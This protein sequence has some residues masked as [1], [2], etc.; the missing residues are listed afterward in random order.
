MQIGIY[1]TLTILRFTSVG[2]YLGDE[3]DNDVLLPNKYLT[4]DLEIDQEIEVFLYK[5]SEDRPV[6]TTETPKIT[7]HSF[8][9][10]QVKSVDSIG[11]FLDWGLEKDL[12]VP[13]K[14]QKSKMKEGGNYL[15]YLYL[16]E[17]TD[18]LV[19][20]AKI[21]R[22]I[23]KETIDLEVGQEVQLLIAEKT[24]LGQK[25]LVEQKYSGLIFNNK[26]TQQLFPGDHAK[27]YVE[28][29][30]EDGKIDIS[31]DQLGFE[32]FDEHTD[33]V[34]SYLNENNSRMFLTDKSD[35]EEIRMMLGMSKKS[36]KKALGNLYKKKI[37]EL[38]DDR[39]E[40]LNK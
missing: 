12:F 11:A 24:D 10:L 34:L 4:D 40:L 22:Y 25:V 31:L 18:R 5:D 14:E 33:K 20:T 3:N 30:R 15:V 19:A 6:A 38:H 36:F 39:V 28:N 9:Y 35:P 32:K 8:A 27:G 7:L 26:I 29:I 23:E 37:V 16:D 17:Q 21:E 13:F 2:A 1:N